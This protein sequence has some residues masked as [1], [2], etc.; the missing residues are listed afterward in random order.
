MGTLSRFASQLKDVRE[1]GADELDARNQ[2]IKNHGQKIPLRLVKELARRQTITLLCQCAED[3]P[4]CHR[5]VLKKLI[6]SKKV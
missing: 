5:R 1:V 3:E 2:T 4:H 6:L